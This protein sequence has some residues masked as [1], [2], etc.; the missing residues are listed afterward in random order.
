MEKQ[1]E[2]TRLTL[3]IPTDEHR[4]LKSMAALTGKSMR[5]V[6]LQ[7]LDYIDIECLVSAHIPNNETQKVLEEIENLENLV[8]DKQAEIIT[9]K[10]GL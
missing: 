10:L 8:R 5:D 1:K 2:L 6:L 7:A 3:D 4:K 9:K